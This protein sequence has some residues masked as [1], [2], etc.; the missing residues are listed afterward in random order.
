MTER[1][2]FD[3]QA[4]KRFS[5]TL[6]QLWLK[7]LDCL[8][9]SRQSSPSCTIPS[10]VTVLLY[11]IERAR[12]FIPNC[13]LFP[14]LVFALFLRMSFFNQLSLIVLLSALILQPYVEATSIDKSDTLSRI[15]RRSASH[16]AVRK[17]KS[18]QVK[19]KAAPAPKV[20]ATKQ[21]TPPKPVE[22]PVACKPFSEHFTTPVGASG[23]QWTSLSSRRDSYS[24]IPGG[25]VELVLN[26]PAGP[27]TLSKDGT[28]NDKLGDGATI[29]STFSLLLS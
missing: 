4:G 21:V 8:C 19:K 16:V 22:K 5:K 25:G 18:R 17:A 1:N 23:S 7:Y 24:M 26:P 15:S 20:A 9:L 11:R 14:Q 28:T 10:S 13:I 3:G 29:N 12:L 2:T 6:F 27:V